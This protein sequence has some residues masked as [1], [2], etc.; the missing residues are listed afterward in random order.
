MKTKTQTQKGSKQMK[1]QYACTQCFKRVKATSNPFVNGL[2]RE[3]QA[4]KENPGK[5]QITLTGRVMRETDKAVLFKPALN[6]QIEVVETWWPKSQ[7]V[8]MERAMANLDQIIVPQWLLEKKQE[9][10]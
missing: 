2:C 3:C 5:V 1:K 10:N 4:E 6:S 9:V 7:I 8:V